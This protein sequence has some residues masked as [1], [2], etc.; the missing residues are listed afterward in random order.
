[1]S[2]QRAGLLVRAHLPKT[3]KMRRQRLGLLAL[4]WSR[5]VLA[6]KKFGQV[7]SKTDSKPHRALNDFLIVGHDTQ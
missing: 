1:M 6:V 2:C 4:R 7:P 5:K 3:R